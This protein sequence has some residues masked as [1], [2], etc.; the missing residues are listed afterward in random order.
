MILDFCFG[1]ACA[2]IGMFIVN[3]FAPLM[4]RQEIAALKARI[5]EREQ[6]E[7]ETCFYVIET[8]SGKRWYGKGSFGVLA[9]CV[10]NSGLSWDDR[11]HVDEL[12][13]TPVAGA[14]DR[15]SKL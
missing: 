7:S 4:Y 14:G 5:A 6:D 1:F 11:I 8:K 2:V 13:A 15:R 3:W 10:L 12:F 9:K